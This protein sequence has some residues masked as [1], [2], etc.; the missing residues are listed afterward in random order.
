MQ[1]IQ[2]IMLA[3]ALVAFAACGGK[4]ELE[5][6]KEQLA[7]MKAEQTGLIASIA[8]LEAEVVKLDPSAKPPQTKLV[9]TSAVGLENF[10]HFIDLQGKIEAVNISYITPKNG[11]GQ[12][13]ALFVKKGD[14]VRKGQLLLQ[15]DN[16]IVKQT[17]AAAEQS[18]QTIK[19]QL[20]FAKTIYQKYKNLWDQGIGTEVQLITAKNNVDNLEA[21]IKATEE[22][23]KVTREQLNF[24]NV[25]S[26]VDGVAEDVN[27]RVGEMFIGVIGNTVQIK[28]V[29]TNNLKITAQ[30]PENYLNK[31]AVGSRLNVTLPDIHKT[32]EANVTVASKLI[33]ANSRSF[34][35][36]AKIPADKDFHPNQIALINIQDY[37]NAK[38][39]TVPVNTLQNDEKGKF[40]MVAVQDG[41]KLVAKKKTVTIGELYGDKQEIKS[42]LAVG[43]VVI[44]EG[45]QGLYEGQLLTIK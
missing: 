29:N 32:I 30:I 38:A 45:Y 39:M 23:T 13:R 4:T 14:A 34:Y 44:V 33:D 40:V 27:V 31:V 37:S 41:K 1:H 28:I 36:E 3:I 43:D 19:T 21:Q 10:T 17:V 35:V 2:K 24:A 42:G 9:T 25:Y 22:Q 15:M 18:V 20:S 26:D 6:K 12:V 5:K 7:K 16:T 8:K 11:G